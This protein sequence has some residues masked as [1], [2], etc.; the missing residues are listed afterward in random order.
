MFECGL[1]NKVSETV[2][3]K[4]G[5]LPCIIRKTC[6]EISSPTARDALGMN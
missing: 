3:V 4:L 5:S 1:L 6:L 2:E